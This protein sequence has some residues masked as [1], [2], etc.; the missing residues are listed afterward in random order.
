MFN[1]NLK[2]QLGDGTNETRGDDNDEMGDA[3]STVD[4]GS[5]FVPVDVWA[6]AYHVCAMSQAKEVKCWGQLMHSVLFKM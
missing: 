1:R 6:G 5:A 3:L 4:L 2:Y